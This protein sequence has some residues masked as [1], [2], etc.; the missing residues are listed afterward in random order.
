[1]IIS[2]RFEITRSICCFF[3]KSSLRF[4]STIFAALLCYFWLA[5]II[6]RCPLF[7]FR[8]HSRLFE[9]YEFSYRIL[10][11]YLMMKFIYFVCHFIWISTQKT[12]PPLWIINSFTIIE[13]GIN[14]FGM[15]ISIIIHIHNKDWLFYF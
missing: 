3:S 10:P 6:H 13:Y 4:C 2:I 15:L 5:R 11:F 1:M 7:L 12:M 8:N 9:D 14:S